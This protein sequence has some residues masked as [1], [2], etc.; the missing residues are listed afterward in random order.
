MFALPELPYVYNALEPF[1][2]EETMRVHHNGHHAAYVKNLNDILSG[3][4]EFL[5]MEIKELLQSLDKVPGEI[6]TKVK[7]NAGGHFHHLF[8]WQIMKPNGGGEPEGNLLSL[9]NDNFK[10][11][12]SFKE[13]FKDSA[14]SLFG[15]GWTW[16][17]VDK[18]NNLE[19]VNLPNQDSP[20]SIGKKPIFTI[21]L[22]EHAYYLKYK[23]KRADFIDAFWN[24]VNWDQIEKNLNLQ[25]SK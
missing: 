25:L 16:L 3:K 8:F 1:I 10:D 4:T 15:S 2:N 11:F 7:N 20:V 6:R 23:N 14:L 5:N 9:I 18:N 13:K 17:V 19:I 22:W 24:V 21:D 12:G